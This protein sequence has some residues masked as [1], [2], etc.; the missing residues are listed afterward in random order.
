[1]GQPPIEVRVRARDDRV[2]ASVTDA[3][4]GMPPEVVAKVFDRFYRADPGR[5]RDHGGTGLGLAIVKSL[6]E[7]HGGEVTCTSAPG[8]GTTFAISLPLAPS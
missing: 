7:A 3:G 5:T 1:M 6:V 2:E 8:R 4:P